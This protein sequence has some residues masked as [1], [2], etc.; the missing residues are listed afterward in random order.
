MMM[1][2]V[3]PSCGGIILGGGSDCRGIRCAMQTDI[4]AKLQQQITATDGWGQNT[5][6]RKW[7]AICVDPILSMAKVYQLVGRLLCAVSNLCLNFH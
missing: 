7:P 6:N 2:T 5:G 4:V 1:S 3:I